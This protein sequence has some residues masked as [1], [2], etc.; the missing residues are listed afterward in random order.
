MR[1]AF[2]TLVEKSEGWR[3]LGRPRRRWE[4][5]IT[6]VLREIVWEVV[7]WINLA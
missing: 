3:L 1:S 5:S 6:R 2:K 7:D 4:D